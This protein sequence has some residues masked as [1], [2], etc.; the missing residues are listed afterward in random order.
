MSSQRRPTGEK[1][2]VH[3]Q[4]ARA[5]EEVRAALTKQVAQIDPD[6][7]VELTLRVRPGFERAD[8]SWTDSWHDSFTDDGKFHDV[9]INLSGLEAGER[10]LGADAAAGREPPPTSR[11][12]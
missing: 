3:E 7:V 5:A 6:L 8:A 9:W 12:T 4:I 11:A 10:E 1:G 2:R